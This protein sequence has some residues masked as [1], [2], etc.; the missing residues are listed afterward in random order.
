MLI[1]DFDT[2]LLKYD[3]NADSIAFLDSMYTNFLLPYIT[4]QHG[5]HRT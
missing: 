2:D 4:T 5:S 1:G 3:R